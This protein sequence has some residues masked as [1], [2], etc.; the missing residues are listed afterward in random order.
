ME[1]KGT[2]GEWKIKNTISDLATNICVGKTRI[3]EVKHYFGEGFPDDP[4][5]EEGTANAKLIV[6]SPIM[7]KA[8]TQFVNDFESDYVLSDGTIVDDP[9]TILLENYKSCKKAIN[10]ALK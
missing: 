6:A 9:N 4:K 2:Q 7:L 10:K 3:A 5:K 8:L 1:F